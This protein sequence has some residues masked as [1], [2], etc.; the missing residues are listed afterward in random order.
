MI[1]TSGFM[2]ILGPMR[3]FA[4]SMSF[5]LL[6]CMA[7]QNLEGHPGGDYTIIPDTSYIPQMTRYDWY[8]IYSAQ[9]KNDSLALKI[10]YG[11]G[12]QKHEFK[13]FVTQNGTKSDTVFARIYH[14]S[15]RDSALALFKKDTAFSI[16]NLKQDLGLKGAIVLNVKSPFD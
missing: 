12:F 10:Y 8:S 7:E 15:Y 13:F 6:A 1:P 4:F 11:G 14:N 5:M 3:W 2:P 9:I 16:G